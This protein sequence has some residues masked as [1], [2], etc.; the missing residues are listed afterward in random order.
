MQRD[1]LAASASAAPD[2]GA[3][4]GREHNRSDLA[5]YMDRLN[6]DPTTLFLTLALARPWLVLGPSDHASGLKMAPARL[7]GDARNAM[8]MTIC[9][10]KV[11]HM[12]IC[13]GWHKANPKS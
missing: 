7:A 3:Q 8:V 12:I 2:V 5:P 6:N 11:H 13:L 10:D 1:P 4:R 9:T